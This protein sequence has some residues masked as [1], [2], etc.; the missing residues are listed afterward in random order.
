MIFDC[1]IHT[2]VETKYGGIYDFNHKE[3]IADMKAAGID[4]GAVYSLS[5]WRYADLSLEDRMNSALEVCKVSENLFPFF[6]IDPLAEN[7]LEQVDIAVEKGFDAFKMIPTFYRIDD[8]K[9]MAVIEKIASVGKPIMFHSGISWD[10]HNTA[11]HHRPGNYEAL[12][13]I[14]NLKFCLAHIS[15]PWTDECIAVFGKFRAAHRNNPTLS[16]EMFV[17]VTPGTP[18]VYRDDVFKKLL[19]TYDMKDNLMFGTDCNTGGY[20]IEFATYWQNTDNALYD[21]YLTQD[22]EEFK[23]HVYCKNLLR[24]LGKI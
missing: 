18:T 16:C 20:N 17:D 12:I 11:D 3:F 6:W 21:K 1:H 24:F 10:D 5:P 13:E 22:V 8:D 15:W 2:R 9:P 23:D 14:P 19:L 4:G 7:A